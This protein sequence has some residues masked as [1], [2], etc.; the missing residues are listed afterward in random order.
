[1]AVANEAMKTKPPR[2]S[3][4]VDPV[5]DYARKVVAG[6][7][8]AGA[9]VRAACQRHLND[10]K[11]GPKRGLDW[12]VNAALRF[13]EFCRVVCCVAVDD[14]Y[15][16]FVLEPS[17]WF[18]AGS[19][20]GWKRKATGKRR[21]RKAY[22]EQGKGNGKSPLAAAIGHY[23]LVADD[24]LAAEVYA[25]ASKKDQAMILFRD[26]VAMYQGSPALKARLTP[27]GGNP[28]WQLT[29]LPTGSFFKPISSE[30]GKSGPRPH[31]SLVD[32]LHEHRD[33]AILNM[34]IAGQKGRKQPLT[35]IIT[36]S[37]TDRQSVCYDH[38]TY[39]IEV[40]TGVKEDD[41]YFSY[42]CAM[43]EGDDP[44]ND[45]S[46]WIKANPL[47]GVTIKP[48]YLE[49]QVRAAKGLGG[50]ANVVKRLNFC[51]WTDAE[52]AAISREVWDAALGDV[53]P[54]ALTAQGYPCFG[55]LDLSEGKDLTAFTLTW[56]LDGTRDAWRFASKTWFWIPR[57]TLQQRIL[58][59][60]TPYD[61]WVERG[62]VEAV[63]GKVLSY[64]WVAEALTEICSKYRPEL[65][66]GDPYGVK[67]LKEHLTDIGSPLQ[68][69]QHPQG[70]NRLILKTETLPDG[71][72]RETDLWMPDAINKFEAALL[73]GRIVIDRNPL[74]TMCAQSV[75]YEPNKTGHRMFRKDQAKNRI[76][77][78]VSASMS[79]SAA[80]VDCARLP[81]EA[82]VMFL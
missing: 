18:I 63:P 58:E 51:I 52:H 47:L 22:V 25:A 44:L 66:C 33:G 79:I 15:V 57:D 2:S 7:I 37:G 32:E 24:E 30:D 53:D 17:Q 10:L 68:I 8:I 55:G 46:C 1:M 6:K 31:G 64:G 72:K 50:Y 56:V 21:F 75:V 76:D 74:M 49:S 71:S 29:H 77:G 42:V 39:A 59:E 19:I 70:F 23:M 28:V 38:H 14:A 16:P 26:A 3:R 82:G 34:L 4:A 12:D 69:E 61:L 36:N 45:P 41:E 48:D 13:G 43:D 73:D 81:V 5:T 65:I 35:F 40:A 20:F 62:F 78:M 67:R 9:P 27:S 80:T 11:D 60:R 54:D